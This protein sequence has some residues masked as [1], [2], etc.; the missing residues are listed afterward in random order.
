M[1][2][3][4]VL[5]SAALLETLW[6]NRKK[7]MLD[8]IAPFVMYATAKLTAP[9]DEIS[10]RDVQ[11]YIQLNF[12]YED[13]PISII[14]RVL[15]RNPFDAIEKRSGLFYLSKPIDAEIEK[16]DK[17]KS[18]CQEHLDYLGNEILTFLTSHCKRAKVKSKD[19]AINSLYSFFSRYSLQVGTNDL[20]S[21]KISPSEYEID[22]YISRYIFECR[23]NHSISYQYLIDLVKGYFLRLAIYIQPDNS[24]IK[25]ATYADL[26]FYYDTP[27]LLD[28]LGYSGKENEENAVALYNMIKRQNG[29]IRCFPH[30][31]S[32]ITNILHAYKRSLLLGHVPDTARTLEGL[33]DRSY[34]PN[35]VDREI[36]LLNSKL[37][38]RFGITE[39]DIPPYATNIDGA[40]DPTHV[41]DENGLKSYIRDHTPHYTD[42]NLENDV[43]SVLAIHRLRGNHTC[44]SIETCH[45]IFVTNNIDFIHAFNFYYKSNVNKHTF[46]LTISASDLSAF[47]WIKC[48]EVSNLPE[49]E[50]L[51]NAYCAMQPI[52]ELM[53]KLEQVF[54][55]LKDSGK[56]TSEQIVALRADRVFRDDIWRYSFGDLTQINEKSVKDVQAEYQKKL[57]ADLAAQHQQEISAQKDS[58]ES[59]IGALQRQLQ[60]EAEEYRGK[61]NAQSYEILEKE[62]SH[63]ETIRKQADAYARLAKQRRLKFYQC[64]STIIMAV[65]AFAFIAASIGTLLFSNNNWPISIAC[66]IC[67]LFD[68]ISVFDLYYSK[69]LIIAK[70]IE[71]SA[72][73]YETKVREK[74]LSEYAQFM[75]YEQT[76]V[77]SV[78]YN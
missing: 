37:E 7:D 76:P 3:N 38:N 10:I 43:T 53:E 12:A 54:Q 51:K 78:D 11:K 34:T 77:S 71:K 74:K 2:T 4:Q 30:V 16:I 17:R 75:E 1:N 24:N 44:N 18:E 25:T 41:L 49:T 22:Y 69:K 50:L 39:V 19:Q 9:N 29:T 70:R 15:S 63:R 21:V 72:A 47:T 8:L 57:T 42:R 58:Y 14:E 61:L 64:I 32:E 27:I 55:K 45:H 60:Q 56:M 73:A 66:A 48:G 36:L 5:V 31:I 46:P 13:I 52:P 62:K 35:D 68:V 28:L 20:A 6:A 33:N 59:K 40:V 23:D 67:T 26:T 65:I